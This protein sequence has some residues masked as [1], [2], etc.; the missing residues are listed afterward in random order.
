MKRKI[1]TVA[2]ASIAG[3]LTLTLL[4]VLLLAGTTP[5]GCGAAFGPA[6]ASLD[7]IAAT[8]RWLESGDDYTA[9]ARGSSASG[10]YQFLDS[11][12]DGYGGY[13]RAAQAPPDVQDAKAYELITAV[14]VANAND[15]SAVP[16]SW[17][18]GHVPPLG[19]REW[20][21]VPAPGAGNRFTPR[22]YQT[23]W[24]DLYRQKLTGIDPAETTTTTAGE[25]SAETS[26][27]PAA[28]SCGSR[29][30]N[31]SGTYALPVERIWYDEHPEWFTKPHHDYPAADLPVP[32]GTPIYAAAAG[33]VVSVTTSGRCG[34]G[35]VINGDD[36]AQYNYCHGL[37]GSH[38]IATGDAVLPGQFL[39]RSASTGNSTGPHLH[40][41]IEAGGAARCP[42]SFFVAV[43]VGPQLRPSDLPT[44]G[45]SF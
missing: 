35:V 18:I 30:L 4:P 21:T 17:Y 36:E 9:Q 37:P 34:I 8:I 19:S 32:T 13:T 33:V 29:P 11:T 22:E 26:T 45:C 25:G 10:A 31:T 44:S 2:G 23:K 3:L 27:S 40:F 14:L 20:D 6:D 7:A 43:V 5:S 42:Q 24:M 28:L 39:M 15:V 38:A 16:V 41:A 12:W 1:T